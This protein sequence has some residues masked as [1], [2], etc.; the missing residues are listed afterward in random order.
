MISKLNA[1]RK[2]ETPEFEKTINIM[3]WALRGAGN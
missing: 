2:G 3:V 1:L